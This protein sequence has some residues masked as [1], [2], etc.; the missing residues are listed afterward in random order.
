MK[1]KESYPVDVYKNGIFYKFNSHGQQGIIKKWVWFQH[2]KENRY[3][4]AFGDYID[5][6]TRRFYNL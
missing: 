6:E 2:Y 3:N 4:L 5:E 1:I